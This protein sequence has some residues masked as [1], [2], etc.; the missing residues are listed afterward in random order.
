MEIKTCT[1]CN[2]ENPNSRYFCESCGT[3]LDKQDYSSYPAFYEGSEMK[4][5][6]IMDNLKHT[7]HT[8][9]LWNDTIDLYTQKVEQFRA[10][11]NL[12]EIGR[13]Y[14]RQ[15]SDKMDD[16][17]DM[18][19]NPEFQIAF[20]GTIKTGK[21]TLIN[22]LLGRNYASMAVTPETAALTK[23]RRSDRDYIDVTFYSA[24][25]W[26]LLWDSRTS[27]AD[28][29]MREYDELDA[30]RQRSRWVG[31]A[32]IHKELLNEKIEAELQIW[33]S[34]KQ[35]EHYFVKE[36]EVG[37]STLPDTFPSQVVLVD[38]P[39]LSDP[40][41][42]RSEISRQY[43]RKADAVFMCIDAQKIQKEEIETIAS[44]F[45]FSSHNKDKVH[46]IATHWDKLNDPEEDWKDQKRHLERQLT[47]KGFF[48][49]VDMA[50]NNIMHAAAYIYNLCRDFDTLSKA[51]MKAL[52]QFAICLDIDPSP[53]SIKRNLKIMME[54]SNIAQI[55]QVMT[56][57]LVE[58]YAE[59]LRE[60]ITRSY[61]DILQNLRRIGQEKREELTQLIETSNED[62][63]ELE[64]A[65]EQKKQDYTDITR[66]QKQLVAALE[67]VIKQTNERVNHVTTILKDIAAESKNTRK[68]KSA[69]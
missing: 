41:A 2:H 15:L 7:P 65:V 37:I 40:V 54:K 11:V 47:G 30:E 38:T 45:S 10:L 5:M 20:V 33:S 23:F 55:Q 61:L 13:D 12:P 69:T 22:S 25:E 60:D 32:P 26:K 46:I 19:R 29:F 9:I 64:K 52:F 6:R 53:Q 31:H 36:I 18:C 56:T 44:V 63:Q 4:L 50:K 42:Y 17:L 49:T 57:K 34:S 48:D 8:P 62:I 58:N 14:Y 1:N 68:K 27:G 66:A 35:A 28:A 67:S 21:S 43:I 24:E 51:G 59:L 3:F 16:F 39:G